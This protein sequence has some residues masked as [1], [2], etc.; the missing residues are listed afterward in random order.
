MGK[1]SVEGKCREKEYE[2]SKGY[3]GAKILRVPG[4]KQHEQPKERNIE[5]FK[6]KNNKS[7]HQPNTTKSTTK[8]YA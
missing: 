3:N 5:S 6:L 2:Y 7:N 4:K 8:P 1:P